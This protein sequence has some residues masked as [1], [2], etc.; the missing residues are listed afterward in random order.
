MQHLFS[1]RDCYNFFV[2]LFRCCALFVR[3]AFS[4]YVATDPDAVLL[5]FSATLLFIW[6]T[7][8]IGLTGQKDTVSVRMTRRFLQLRLLL[9]C[10]FI[11]S[12]FIL[13]PLFLLLVMLLSLLLILFQGIYY[14][15]TFLRPSSET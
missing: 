6:T 10:L 2:S 11:G 5:F 13:P 12:F 14:W 9:K 15:T 1:T 7:G 4:G 3:S 8:G